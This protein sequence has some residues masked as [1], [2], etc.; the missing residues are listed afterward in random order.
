MMKDLLTALLVN[1]AV[2]SVLLL[3]MLLLRRL[4]GKRLSPALMLVLWALVVVKLLIPYG[5]ESDLAVFFAPQTVA[6]APADAGLPI[7]MPISQD[8]MSP[9]T[10]QTDTSNSHNTLNSAN[11]SVEP[12]DQTATPLPAASF[13]WMTLALGIWAAGALTVSVVF[14]IG[15]VNIRRRIRHAR[16]Q[17]PDCLKEVLEECKALLGVKCR[18]GLCVQSTFGMPVMMGA[19]RPCLVLPEKALTLD[20]KTLRHIMLHELAHLQR[21]D[22]LV[23]TGLNLLSAVYWFN[24]LTWLCFK[25]FRDDIETAC[26]H[27]VFKAVGSGARL[28]YIDTILYFAGSDKQQRLAAAM[29]LSHRP[30]AMEKRIK[31]MF[32]AARTHTG[33]RCAAMCVALLMLCVSVFTAC[34]PAEPVLANKADGSLAAISRT[35]EPE[36]KYDAPARWSETVESKKLRIVFDND[37]ELPE[38]NVYPVIKVESLP[39]T[40]QKIDK[41]VKYFAGDKKL[42]LPHIRTK[43]EY[44]DEIANAKRGIAYGEA[45][46]AESAEAWAWE[47]EQMRSNAPDDSPLIYTD[48][49]LTYERDMYGNDITESGKNFLSVKFDNDDGYPGAISARNESEGYWNSAYFSYANHFD[50]YV[51]QS[52]YQNTIIESGETEEETGWTGAGALFDTFA[53]D[54]D[55]ALEKANQVLSDLDIKDMMLVSTEKFVAPDVPEKSGYMFEF[56]RQAGGIPVYD[57]RNGGYSKDEEPPAYASPIGEET[58]RLWVSKDGIEIFTW[59]GQSR[60]VETVTDNVKLLPFEDIQKAVKDSISYR[61]SFYTL[62]YVSEKAE[63]KVTA[64]KLKTA[65]IGVKDNPNQAL[66]VP[67]WVVESTFSYDNGGDPET[68]YNDLCVINAIDGGEIGLPRF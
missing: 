60:V 6:A 7:S 61:K 59:I 40:Q 2:F 53:A 9:D 65:Y 24:P 29:A 25:L 8:S 31:G 36:V 12:A 37:I 34:Q 5:F 48:T 45:V 47:L 50:N 33:A 3:L 19:M 38:T 10:P 44:D 49:T 13:D 66:I 11:Q 51:N 14:G 22:L 58:I 28:D 68:I 30:S 20:K 64:V 46:D 1:A 56:A 54:K 62:G 32:K 67:A 43:A 26:D 16:I 23:I 17:T 4:L 52:M 63:V 42:Y 35:A 41:L 18:V 57:L 15:T 55:A 21:G 39:M 27:S